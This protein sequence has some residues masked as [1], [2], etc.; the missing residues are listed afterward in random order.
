VGRVQVEMVCGA[1]VGARREQAKFFKLLRVQGR[2]GQK[3]EPA[4]D[5]TGNQRI[6]S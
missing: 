2:N 1:G 3:I 4:Q 5:S 6:T